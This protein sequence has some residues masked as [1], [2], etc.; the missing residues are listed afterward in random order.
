MRILTNA[1]PT[2]SS[3]AAAAAAA[4]EMAWMSKGGAQESTLLPSRK[5]S[6]SQEPVMLSRS[7]LRL[8]KEEIQEVKN[9]YV[10]FYLNNFKNHRT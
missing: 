8:W 9:M 2:R 7:S 10:V 6:I 5:L 1:Q 3:A 4:V